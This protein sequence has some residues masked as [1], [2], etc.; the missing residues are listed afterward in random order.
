MR[1]HPIDLAHPSAISVLTL[2]PI[3]WRDSPDLC[4]VA[5]R[6]LRTEYSTTTTLLN[7][8]W[9]Q[10]PLWV[11]I[12][13]LLLEHD[14][15]IERQVGLGSFFGCPR[16]VFGT[17]V[18]F[19][20]V[21]D[22]STSHSQQSRHAPDCVDDA[23]VLMVGDYWNCKSNLTDD[24]GI[25]FL[26]LGFIAKNQSN[27]EVI[28]QLRRI[29]SKFTSFLVT[30]A[31]CSIPWSEL[32][33]ASDG[34][35]QYPSWHTIR[36]CGSLRCLWSIYRAFRTAQLPGFLTHSESRT[37]MQAHCYIQKCFNNAIFD[38]EL[39]HSTFV[40]ANACIGFNGA[41]CEIIVAILV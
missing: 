25:W 3:V 10:L 21:W 40:Q 17:Q 34:T 14:W 39:H 37:N 13:L 4:L 5:H 19:A 9:A 15:V 35:R 29:H 33:H 23:A 7:T 22:H 16:L 6:G 2:E 8:K 32:V 27:W 18:A 11:P 20:H 1:T 38:S 36:E 12:M 24:N 41:Q 26:V 31:L 30:G 28:G